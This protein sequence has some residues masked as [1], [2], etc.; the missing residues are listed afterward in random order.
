VKE[1]LQFLGRFVRDPRTVG[2]IAPSSRVLARA[3][4]D[5]L[6]LS[7]S[8]HVIE[9]GP[10]TGSFTREVIDRLGPAARF[11]AV[12]VNPVFADGLRARWP[13]L[14]CLCA[15]AEG[16]ETIAGERGLR[17]VDHIISGLP[18]ASLPGEISR[19]IMDAIAATLRPGGTFTTFQYIHGY[20][21]P[22]AV[23]FRRAMAARLGPHRVMSTVM[24]NVPPAFVLRW[25]LH[26]S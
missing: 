21:L 15:S 26:S 23:K 22:L 11:L 6:D 8:V 25:T 18:F 17:P 10:G 4:V 2:A 1:Q 19:R 16:L 7:G 24:R 20:G 3:M 9:L 13:S 14:E 12:E 5:G